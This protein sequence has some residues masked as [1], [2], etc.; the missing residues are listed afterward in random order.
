MSISRKIAFNTIFSSGAKI[1]WTFLALITMGL[2]TRTLGVDG[3][4]DYSTVM[5]VYFLLAAVADLGLNNIV[6]REIAKKEGDQESRLIS[7]ALMIRFVSSIVL[8]GLTAVFVWFLNYE[9]TVKEGI[10]LMSLGLFFGIGYQTLSAIFQKRL[11]AYLVS[12]A[13]FVGRVVNLAWVFICFKW[14]LGLLWVLSGM[15]LSW[16]ATFIIV[17]IISFK[18]IKLRLVWDPKEAKR[19]IK[20]SLPLGIS[21]IISFLYFKVN[22]LLLAHLKEST[23]V[24]IYGAAYKIVENVAY[25]PAMFMGLILPLFALY[26][27]KDQKKFNKVAQ[28]SFDALAFLG[29]GMSA[30]IF[31]LAPKIIAIIAGTGFEASILVLQILT[32][33]IAGIFFGQYFNMLLITGK[34]QKEL[35]KIFSIAAVFNITLNLIFIPKHSYLAAATILSTTEVLVAVLSALWAKKYCEYSLKLGSFFK[36]ILSA[37]VMMGFL[38]IINHWPIYVQIILGSGLYLIFVF[39][40]KAF[41]KEELNQIIKSK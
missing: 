1:S 37:G 3:F 23:D 21:A 22:T 35:L 33:S 24:G 25:F 7:V 2:A 4:G 8:I 39:L 34:K 40:T 32:F 28:S 31:V 41:T 27:L 12:I 11:T 29:I 10:L 14:D 17:L 30:G 26:Y 19:L 5:A 16:L 15:I 13:E 20:S 9:E 38:M 36:I 6:L 18:T